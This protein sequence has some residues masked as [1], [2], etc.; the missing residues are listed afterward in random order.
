MSPKLY[1]AS[2]DDKLLGGFV[3]AASKPRERSAGSFTWFFPKRLK[4]ILPVSSSDSSSPS[5][6]S[7]PSQKSEGAFEVIEIT[8]Q[9][10][11]DVV[12]HQAVVIIDAQSSADALA[13]IA[14]VGPSRHYSTLLCV[15]LPNRQELAEFREA[16]K[17]NWVDAFLAESVAGKEHALVQVMILKQVL[18][19]G[20]F[21][22]Y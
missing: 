7:P 6:P 17:P 19:L 18:L 20:G 21:L 13:K 11:A 22:G 4:K 12:Q 14:T 3:R 2:N 15:I 9:D 5:P 10:L 8:S 1:V 16:T